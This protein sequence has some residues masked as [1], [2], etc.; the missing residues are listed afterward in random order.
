MPFLI[1]LVVGLGFNKEE[2]SLLNKIPDCYEVQGMRGTDSHGSTDHTEEKALPASSETMPNSQ[3]SERLH[4]AEQG[5]GQA[6]TGAWKPG[7]AGLNFRK[8]ISWSRDLY[9]NMK[10]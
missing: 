8:P 3:V 9:E 1:T 2:R 7:K 5:S 10:T 6:A 4:S